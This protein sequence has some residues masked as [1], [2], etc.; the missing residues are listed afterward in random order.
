MPVM[1]SN[2]NTNRFDVIFHLLEECYGSPVCK[3]EGTLLDE[4]IHTILSQATSSA[5]YTA[6]YNELRN[7]YASWD[8][9]RNADVRDIEDAIRMGGLAKN[10][11]VTIK[12]ILNEIYLEHGKLNINFLADMSDDDAIEYLMHFNGVGI[13]TAACVLMFS[14]CRNVLPVDTHVHRI[15]IRLNLIDS[16][17]SPEEAYHHLKLVCASDKRYS[18]HGRRVCKSVKPL[19]DLCCL[20]AICDFG[21]R[22]LESGDI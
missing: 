20:L 15:C 2:Q 9:V 3:P 21:A 4:L 8:D 14:L 12:K 6:A 11:A 1:K 10:K 18:T 16:S 13:K 7:Q 19:C 17:V 22:R 5:N